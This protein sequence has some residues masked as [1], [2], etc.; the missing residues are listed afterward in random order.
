[1]LLTACADSNTNL[2]SSTPNDAISGSLTPGVAGNLTGS[3]AA[4]NQTKANLTDQ[5]I[6]SLLSESE[7]ETI[8]N[9]PLVKI[10]STARRGCTFSSPVTYKTPFFIIAQ[11]AGVTSKQDFTGYK[12]LLRKTTEIKGIGEEAFE[13]ESSKDIITVIF[14]SKNRTFRIS[15]LGGEVATNNDRL[16][17]AM[18]V[19][20]LIQN[21]V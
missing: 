7:V 10:E 17:V 21:R 19:A 14:F 15:A 13:D 16:N 20:Q 3:P 4:T 2:S 12:N 8:L 1:L 18:K 5:D 6:C 9:T 11:E